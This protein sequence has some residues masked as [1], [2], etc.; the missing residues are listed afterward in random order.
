[1]KTDD[2]IDRLA[3][4]LAPVTPLRRPGWRAA[5][6]AVGAGLYV[7]ALTVAMAQPGVP[8]ETVG[9]LLLVSQI[10]AAATGVLAVLAAFASVVPGHSR[11]VFAWPIVAAVVWLGALAAGSIGGAHVGTV[12]GAE[13]EW[14]CVAVIVLG[15]APLVAVLAAMLRHGAPLR[16]STTGALVAVAAGALTNVGACFSRPH[17]DDAVTLAWHGG[18]VLALVVL[19]V[20][21]SRFVL[22]WRSTPIE[23]R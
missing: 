5:A 3:T 8:I 9:R 7:L 14:V 6:W 23:A 13:S 22:N 17:T 19:C 20:L 18:A 4:D 11:G 16:P 15:G 1:M 10:A 2:L 21:A 12:L